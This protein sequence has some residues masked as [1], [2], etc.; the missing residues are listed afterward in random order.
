MADEGKLELSEADRLLRENRFAEAEALYR[1]LPAA[2]RERPHVLNNLAAALNG[3]RRGEEAK[4][5]L[6]K[7]LPAYPRSAAVLCNLAIAH[8]LCG[9]HAEA[10]A[11]YRKAIA[12]E[13]KRGSSHLQFAQFLMTRKALEQAGREIEAAGALGVQ[14]ADAYAEL[15]AC[16]YNA[17][18]YDRALAA[19]DKAI[20]LVPDHARAHYGRALVWLL[21]ED[22]ARG[23]KEHE[24]REKVDYVSMLRGFEQPKWD[25]SDLRGK[26]ILVHA[27][28]GYGDTLQFVRYLPELKRRGATVHFY[29]DRVLEETLKRTPGYDAFYTKRY[30]LRTD[31]H[32]PLMSLPGLLGGE[33]PAP[34]PYVGV[35]PERASKWKARVAELRG[36]RRIGIVW[37]GRPTHASD[38]A[39]SVPLAAFVPVIEAFPEDA[40]VSLQGGA[41]ARDI[42][43]VT[44]PLA[45]FSHDFADTAA[46]LQAL[47]L[48]ICVD[49]SIA[50]LA[51]ALGRPV[52]TLLPFSPDFRWGLHRETTPWYPTMRLLRQPRPGDWCSVFAVLREKLAATATPP[53]S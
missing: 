16:H 7:V 35:E 34:I 13:P 9:E 43:A 26:S 53:A 2:L 30:P 11:A 14:T 1:R 33:I 32:C 10:E 49:T 41:A 24:W 29:C 4:A 48:A 52:W 37:A 51:G 44:C 31:F 28:Q 47:D 15:A 20:G 12:A 50:H 38:H 18:E 17:G 46:I 3:L 23:W 6:A 36:R 22:Y 45:D 21:K 40:F 39:R 8:F 19:C 5:A 42:E 27:E 25:G